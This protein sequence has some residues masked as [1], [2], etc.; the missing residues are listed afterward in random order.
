MPPSEIC[1]C[2]KCLHCDVSSG[3][4][5]AGEG[6][7]RKAYLKRREE[8]KQL[9]APRHLAREGPSPASNT[10]VGL[11]TRASP[12]WQRSFPNRHNIEKDVEAAG[13]DSALALYLPGA[14][15]GAAKL[16]FRMRVSANREGKAW[17]CLT[18]HGIVDE[19]FRKSLFWFDLT[20]PRSDS[21]VVPFR[22]M[23]NGNEDSS[24]HTGTMNRLARLL[25]FPFGARN[26][27][28]AHGWTED[29]L[30]RRSHRFSTC[31]IVLCTARGYLWNPG[32]CRGTGNGAQ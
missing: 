21:A 8:T 11:R 25:S 12:A 6:V 28:R 13:R 27:G 2:T 7:R 16:N 17:P 10:L 15:R 14:P 26:F 4:G 24:N 3:R 20:F 30:W 29:T 5:G 23:I 1:G 31:F 19:H 22:S 18:Q 9:V 32:S